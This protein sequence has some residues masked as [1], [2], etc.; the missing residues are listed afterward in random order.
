[1]ARREHSQ[2]PTSVTNR[3]VVQEHQSSYGLYFYQ[4]PTIFTHKISQDQFPIY[5]GMYGSR[6]RITKERYIYTQA[7]IQIQGF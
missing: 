5:S 1:M 7:D 4:W 2:S 3:K 6:Q